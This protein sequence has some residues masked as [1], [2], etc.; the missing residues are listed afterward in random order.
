MSK[1]EDAR[2]AREQLEN[3]GARILGVAVWGLTDGSAAV[4]A[5][6]GYTTR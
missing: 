1:R 6:S 3:I 4:R 5:Y 2:A